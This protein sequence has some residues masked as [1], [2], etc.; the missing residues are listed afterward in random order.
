MRSLRAR[1]FVAI[2]GAVLVAVG[3]SLALGVVLTK[4]AVR[5]TIRGD[6]EA[7]AEAFANQI[8]RLPAGSALRLRAGA[9]PTPGAAR[10]ATGATAGRASFQA[11]IATAGEGGGASGHRPQ[12]RARPASPAGFGGLGPAAG[13]SADGTIEVDGAQPDLRRRARPAAR[14]SSSPV[15]TSSPATTSAATSRPC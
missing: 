10:A 15:L 5:D 13:D 11:G 3:A 8:G 7:Q 12:P 1:L 4:S 2:L 6:V 14:S 9:P